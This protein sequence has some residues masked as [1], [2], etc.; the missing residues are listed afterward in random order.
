MFF[1]SE[2]VVVKKKF[3]VTLKAAKQS[4]V[5]C[6]KDADVVVAEA[7]PD[8]ENEVAVDLE[9]DQEGVGDVGPALKAEQAVPIEVVLD[10]GSD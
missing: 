8:H 4:L 9:V 3:R 7:R 6:Q 10:R 2:T 5:L 1:R